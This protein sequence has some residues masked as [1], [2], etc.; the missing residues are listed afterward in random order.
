VLIDVLETFESLS[1]GTELFPSVSGSR[2]NTRM[3]AM[4]PAFPIQL[5]RLQ[6]IAEESLIK[7]NGKT[8][9]TILTRETEHCEWD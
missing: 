8:S 5:I 4:H 3:L 2:F 7:A 1:L 9:A 6:K